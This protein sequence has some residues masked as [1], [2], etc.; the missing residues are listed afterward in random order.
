M[1]RITCPV[2]QSKLNAKEELAG[3]TR[4]C[5]KCSNPLVIPKA[6]PTSEWGD[7]ELAVL[8]EPPPDQHVAVVNVG[9]LSEPQLPERLNRQSRYLVCDRTS[10]FATWQNNGQGWLLKTRGGTVSAAR[11]PELLPAQGNYV[12]VELSLAAV[13]EGPRLQAIHSFKLAEHWAL[14][15]LVQG[16]DRICSRITGL[17]TL[18]KEQKMAVRNYLAETLMREIWQDARDVLDYLAGSDYPAPGM[19]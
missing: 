18:G 5:P 17:A 12:L 19:P 2:C 3:Q 4:K 6:D 16:D 11:N 8:D 7:R 13:E 9:R 15:T 14:N 1:I 10:V